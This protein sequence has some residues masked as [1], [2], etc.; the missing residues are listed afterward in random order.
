MPETLSIIP[1][2]SVKFTEV[3]FKTLIS[4]YGTGTEQRRSKTSTGRLEI[5][6]PLKY[7]SSTDLSTLYNFYVARY[8]A[9][10]AFNF[11]YNSVTYLVRF[12]DDGLSWEWFEANWASGSITLIQVL[13]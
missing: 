8:G 4:D 1:W 3:G 10:V 7:L 5:S 12:K 13:A 11:V 6:F 2:Y 9:T